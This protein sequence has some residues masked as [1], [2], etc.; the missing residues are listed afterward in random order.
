MNMP[1]KHNVLNSL[2]AIALALELEISFET[3]QQAFESFKGVERRFSFNGLYKGAEI[4]DDY[5][6]H[7]EEI[8]NTIEVAARRKK[9]KLTVIFEPHR[10]TRT[11]K[12][13]DLFLD[14]FVDFSLDHLIVTD[15]Y[16]AS[17]NPIPSI[18]A[19]RFVRELQNRNPA[20][21]VSYVPY[22]DEFFAIKKQLD[23]VV[24]HDDLVL[25]Q[26]A[27]RINK[28]IKKLEL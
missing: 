6:H 23:A 15:I 4:F 28:L 13:W 9:K 22:D 18:T 21:S 3:I 24:G 10:Y 7:P 12:L 5:G 25:L 16:A 17:E 26:G 27:G 1:G 20:F 11:D 19:E 8:K 2:A 14:T